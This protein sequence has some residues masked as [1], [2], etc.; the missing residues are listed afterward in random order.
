MIDCWICILLES[1]TYHAPKLDCLMCIRSFTPFYKGDF[2]FF[3]SWLA[4][5]E[6]DRI[7]KI[8]FH[9]I[10]IFPSNG[11]A[12]VV[13]PFPPMRSSLT[14]HSHMSVAVDTLFVRFHT[15]R[16]TLSSSSFVIFVFAPF[17]KLLFDISTN[18]L[19][20]ECVIV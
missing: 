5:K 15:I 18:I 12:S 6:L 1:K 17:T 20:H 9:L 3:N 8:V 16:L 13:F 19:C 14:S 7:L 10:S 2:L 4:V 11:V